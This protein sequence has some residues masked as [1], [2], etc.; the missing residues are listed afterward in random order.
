MPELFEEVALHEVE[1]E[2]CLDVAEAHPGA[3]VATVL[4]LRS[5]AHSLVAEAKR[6]RWLE[7]DA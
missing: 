7:Q 2:D 6:R 3:P 5:I 4:L 1:A